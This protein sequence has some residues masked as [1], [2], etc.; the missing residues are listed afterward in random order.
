MTTPGILFG[1]LI[2]SILG[3]SFH[4]LRGGSFSRLLLH[5]FSAWIAFFVGHFVGEWT[6]WH[7]WRYGTLN[8]FPA[9]LATIVGLIATNILAGP[10][11]PKQR[12]QR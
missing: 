5:V 8:F 7:L 10:E 12:K 4:F 3:L 11:K 6:N 2:S 1:F 9:I